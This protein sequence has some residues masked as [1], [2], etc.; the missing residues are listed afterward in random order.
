MILG[1]L[2]GMY[3]I[4]IHIMYGAGLRQAE[5]LSLRVKD[6]DFGSNNIFVRGGKGNK[7]R[8]TI[9]PDKVTEALFHQINFVATIHERDLK[10]GFGE[11]YMPFALAKKYPSASRELSWQFLFPSQ[12]IA[13]DPR[14]GKPKRHHRHQRMIQTA[15]KDAIRKAGIHKHANCH[16][17][18]HSFA[19]HLLE[20]G[21]SRFLLLQNRHT[22][23]PCR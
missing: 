3:K 23:H 4:M 10:D 21:Y 1:H 5:V 17:F 8:R 9:M 7:D 6:I 19:T 22:L 15:V 11:V 14:D 20:Q 12:N 13:R 16:T 2:Q 18:R